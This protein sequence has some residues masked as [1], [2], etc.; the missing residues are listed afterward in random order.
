[1]SLDDNERAMLCKTCSNQGSVTQ[2]T[3]IQAKGLRKYVDKWFRFTCPVGHP[4]KLQHVTFWPDEDHDK[5][6][7]HEEET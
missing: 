2:F 6:I 5:G 7:V 3:L 1:M 4:L